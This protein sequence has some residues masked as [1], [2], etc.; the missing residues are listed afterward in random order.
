MEWEKTIEETIRTR[1]SCRSYDARAIEDE[2]IQ[3]LNAFLEDRNQKIQG[4]RFV[5]LDLKDTNGKI[6]TYGMIAG[7][8]NYLAGIIDRN[9]NHIEDLGLE[10]EKLILYAT[11][12][13]LGTCWLAG[14]DR[15]T[16]DGK[17]EL[18]ENEVVAVAS[19]VGY[20]KPIG[21]KEGLVRRV[22]H[23][24]K[25][26]PW[27]ELF[28]NEKPGN[29]LTRDAAGEYALPLEMVRLSPSASNKQPWRLICDGGKIHFCLLRNKGYGAEQ[30]FDIQRSDIGIAMCH[31]EL[32]AAR[33][34]LQ[35]KWTEMNHIPQYGQFVYIK[36]WDGN[37]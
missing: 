27:E 30:P 32:T 12:L 23:A 34:K 36:T 21:L 5:L 29:P 17:V 18:T 10:F 4:E 31:F 9:N 16:F 13:G 25:K 3:K 2:K 28:F 8:R 26:K 20:A 1:R 24:D 19:P 6:G 33:L 7:A 14:I 22:I 15:R 11:S 37:A 35:G